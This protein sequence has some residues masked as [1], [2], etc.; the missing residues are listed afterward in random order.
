MAL[1]INFI[2]GFDKDILG[3]VADEICITRSLEELGHKVQRVPRDIWKASVDGRRNK[4]W[5]NRLPIKADI[6]IIC[7]WHH[8]TCGKY[9][10][11]LRAS[12]D[13]PVFYWTFDYM[14]WPNVPGWHLEMAK[15][16]NLHLTHEMGDFEHMKGV[17]PYYFSGSFADDKIGRVEAEKIYD[18][19]FTGSYY[20]MGQR[21]DWVKQINEKHK[22]KVFSHNHEEWKKNGLEAYPPVYKD[23]YS[24]LI[25]QSKIVLGFNQ[26]D[27]CYGY[28]SNRV[29][30]VLCVG[31]FL[32]HRYVPG[33][34]LFL[35]DGAEYFSSVEEAVAKIGFY[36]KNADKREE[37]AARGYNIG[38]EGFSSLARAKELTILIE[39]YLEGGI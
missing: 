21:A 33:M 11:A 15:A 28:W 14:K 35:K 4:D 16:A 30:R 34:E 12:T 20:T 27:Y 10:R 13:A 7:K 22:V 6:N 31:G 24:K 25:A 9:I 2:G 17:K 19:I 36:L 18:V 26:V 5:D 8:F 37:I 39:R 1:R 29:A 3:D 38:L 32:L 23:E